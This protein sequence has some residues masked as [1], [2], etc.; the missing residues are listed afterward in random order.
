MT[1]E[2]S[3]P[4]DT[5]DIEAALGRMV[6]QA[7]SLEM[8]MRFAGE[9]LATAQATRDALAS[10]TAGRLL[11]TVKAIAAQRTEITP[12]EL[13]EL[14]EIVKDAEPHLASRNTY[15]HGAWGEVDGDLLAMNR[16]P[17]NGFRTR[18]LAVADLE[19]LAADLQALVN[20]TIEWTYAALQKTHSHIFTADDD[21]QP[22][23]DT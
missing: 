5:T 3:A 19:T 12:G 1:A 13:T 4:R 15:I 22:G 11:P 8:V 7:A 23:D 21:E 6:Y 10:Q 2:K 18:P 16:R 9:M 14:G 20:R 17:K